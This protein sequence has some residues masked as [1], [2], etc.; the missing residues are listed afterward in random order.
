MLLHKFLLIFLDHDFNADF[1]CNPI[2][3]TS[4]GYNYSF[5]AHITS[6]IGLAISFHWEIIKAIK[7][8]KKRVVAG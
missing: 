7:F 1:N 5:I 2:A 4:E 6:H 8:F 3:K